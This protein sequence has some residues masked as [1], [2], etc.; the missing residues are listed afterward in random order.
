[1][2]VPVIE[3]SPVNIE[4]KVTQ[5]IE[6]GS[7]DMFLAEV[8]AVLADEKYMDETGKFDLNIYLHVAKSGRASIIIISRLP[9]WVRGMQIHTAGRQPVCL[10]GSLRKQES[11]S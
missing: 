9:S 3:E 8:T 7:H 2:S 6:L 5:V 4:C 11:R 10:Q 1:M